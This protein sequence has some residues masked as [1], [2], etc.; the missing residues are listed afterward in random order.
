MKMKLNNQ[1]KASASDHMQF[2][3]SYELPEEIATCGAK[4]WAFWVAIARQ[5]L[6][7]EPLPLGISTD[8]EYAINAANNV[9]CKKKMK[10]SSRWFLA[11][12]KRNPTSRISQTLP[13]YFYTHNIAGK[14][15]NKFPK[16]RSIV[17]YSTLTEGN[18]IS[19]CG[20]MEKLSLER[21][22]AMGL[23]SHHRVP[24]PKRQECFSVEL[25]FVANEG[26]E[27]ADV[28]NYFYP[29]TKNV[30]FVGDGSVTPAAGQVSGLY[31]EVRINMQWGKVDRLYETC[32][33]LKKSGAAVNKSC[34]L[35]VHL[36]SRHLTAR[37]E[38]TRRARLVAAL[39]WLL[40]L[41]PESRRNNSFC[42]PNV[43]GRAGRHGRYSAINPT[44]FRKHRTTEIR[45]G[46]GTM[47]PDKVLNW[48]TLLHYISDSSKRLKTFES[49][50][51]SKAPQHIKIW[52]VL[53]R[54]KFFPSPGVTAEPNENPEMMQVI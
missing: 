14:F 39:P 7:K 54:N 22:Q 30:V 44:S 46:S 34:G 17:G 50:L 20:D 10:T 15:R 41:V 16:A 53:R 2:N 18:V 3:S 4:R 33:K 48:A 21:R 43:P 52:A 19:R 45:L 35:H 37:G 36:D 49:F 38:A 23:T 31:K 13:P 6:S 24:M 12:R 40:E 47:D 5:H 42:L 8:Y 26:S 28:T 11:S 32:A 27:M 29:F 9:K 1:I 51:A 25:E